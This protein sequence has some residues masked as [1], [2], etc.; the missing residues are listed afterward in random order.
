MRCVAAIIS[1]HLLWLALRA[2]QIRF[3]LN[4]RRVS[5][6]HLRSGSKVYRSA[7]DGLWHFRCDTSLATSGVNLSLLFQPPIIETRVDLV[8][9]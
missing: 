7:F 8:A 3:D 2:T 4:S 1:Q 6:L 5:C 9:L